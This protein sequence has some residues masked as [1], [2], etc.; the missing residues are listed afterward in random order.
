ME[1]EKCAAASC[2]IPVISASSS[3]DDNGRIYVS[4]TNIDPKN[5]QKVQLEI[6]GVSPRSV[7][8]KIITSDKMQDHNTFENSNKV[9]LK[10]FSGMVISGCNV[11]V[12]MPAKSIVTLE[13]E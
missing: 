2:S 9:E 6:S 12:T 11:M 7:N 5:Q 4:M 8:G 13:I 1:S 10:D 3:K